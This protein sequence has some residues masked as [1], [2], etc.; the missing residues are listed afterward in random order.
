MRVQALLHVLV[1]FSFQ[2]RGFTNQEMRAVLAQLL[3]LD[4]ANYPAGRMTYDLRRL[5]LHGLIQ[6][7]P[8]SHRYEV[9]PTGL[10]V[11]LFLSRTCDRL[12]RPKLAEIMPV[13]PPFNSRS[14]LPLTACR[15]KSNAAARSKTSPPEI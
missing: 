14:G 3:G 2:L 6:R 1:L 7:V 5:R 10:R 12:L 4:P 9:T 13:G 11:A 8:K 15:T